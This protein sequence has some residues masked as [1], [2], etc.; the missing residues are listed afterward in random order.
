MLTEETRRLVRGLEAFAYAAGIPPEKFAVALS[1]LIAD[2]R[3]KNVQG[4]DAALSALPATGALSAQSVSTTKQGLRV[5]RVSSLRETIA[6]VL[7]QSSTLCLDNE[8]ERDELC[9]RL[10]AVLQK[11]AAL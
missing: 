8:G 3:A 9:D 6:R 7:V 1:D 10:V 11:H 4:V 5:E 2:M